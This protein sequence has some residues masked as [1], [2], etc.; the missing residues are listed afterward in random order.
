[1]IYVN[2]N[3]AKY[4]PIISL[5]NHHVPKTTDSSLDGL[6]L[7]MADRSFFSA[8]HEWILDMKLASKW[9]KYE[10]SCEFIIMFRSKC[11]I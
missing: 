11:V 1:M 4:I 9:H 2:L 3:H 7:E 8:G 6:D 5:T 10:D